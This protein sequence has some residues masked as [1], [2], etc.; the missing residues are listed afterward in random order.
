MAIFTRK[1]VYAGGT[2]RADWAKAASNP[3][4]GSR[5]AATEAPCFHRKVVP[6]MVTACE[7]YPFVDFSPPY[8][9]G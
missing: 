2:G 5:Q 1:P 3:W 6:R 9:G 8:L 4:N 7:K